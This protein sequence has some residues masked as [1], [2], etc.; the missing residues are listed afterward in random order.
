MGIRY[1]GIEVN[2]FFGNWFWKFMI[3]WVG[4]EDIF[5]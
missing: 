5:Y 2:C 3:E 1:F 4:W